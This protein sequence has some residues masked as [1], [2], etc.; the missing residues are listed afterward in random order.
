MNHEVHFDKKI[1]DWKYIGSIN[2]SEKDN[3]NKLAPKLT[4][5]HIYS[6]RTEKIKVKLATQVLSHSVS[7]AICF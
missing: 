3:I 4:K 7:P 2:H 1:A 5:S 6:L